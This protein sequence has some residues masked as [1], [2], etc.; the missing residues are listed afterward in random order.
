MKMPVT[1]RHMYTEKV[2]GFLLLAPLSQ[3]IFT[4]SSPRHL[5]DE[6]FYV[7]VRPFVPNRNL[8]RMENRLLREIHGEGGGRGGGGVEANDEE[9]GHPDANQKDSHN[10]CVE[11]NL[12]FFHIIPGVYVSK[13][14]D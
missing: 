3:R 7:G 2:H 8:S 10:V 6:G 5:E 4:T 12:H 1:H 13:V 11:H 9:V 14:F